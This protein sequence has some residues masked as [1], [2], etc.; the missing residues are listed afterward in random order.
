M[1]GG[2]GGAVGELFFFGCFEPRRSV[3]DDV[4]VCEEEGGGGGGGGRGEGRGGGIGIR[5]W[6]Q[7]GSNF[8]LPFYV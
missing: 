4:S 7:N 2:G 5:L 8:R 6:L 1:S 3:R